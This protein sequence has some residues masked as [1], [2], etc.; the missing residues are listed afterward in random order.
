MGKQKSDKKKSWVML[1][2][3]MILLIVTSGLYAEYVVSREL[4]G[5]IQ[6]GATIVM[7]GML[8]GIVKKVVIH[9]ANILE[10]EIY[11]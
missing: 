1:T 11:K 8:I 3:Y 6:F 2:I 10:L 9:L 5:Y 4:D 7:V